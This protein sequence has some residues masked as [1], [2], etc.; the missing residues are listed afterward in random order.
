MSTMPRVVDRGAFQLE[1]LSDLANDLRD[2]WHS[3]DNNLTQAF[4]NNIH[5]WIHALQIASDSLM[6]GTSKHKI[7]WNKMLQFLLLST[8][9][10]DCRDLTKVLMMACQSILPPNLFAQAKSILENKSGVPDGPALSRCRF[11]VD[12]GYMVFRRNM[13]H[14]PNS[15]A[16]ERFARYLAWDSSPQFGRDYELALVRSIAEASLH[17]LLRAVHQ[18]NE[19][20]TNFQWDDEDEL[21]MAKK[22]E[23]DLMELCSGMIENHAVPAVQIGFGSSGFAM[24][25]ASR[26]YYLLVVCVCERINTNSK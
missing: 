15:Q 10:R 1:E 9:L 8:K 2:L 6:P 13:N 7:N 25:W 16:S 17:M 19:M 20:W 3:H 11:L 5:N 24:N 12:A 22:R 23:Q 14:R 21:A 18:M 26:L 4:K